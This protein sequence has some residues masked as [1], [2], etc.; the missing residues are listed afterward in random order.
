MAAALDREVMLNQVVTGIRTTRGDLPCELVIIAAG[1]RP[2]NHLAKAAGLALGRTGGIIV[3]KHMRTSDPD[4]YAGGD[5]VEI[6][7]LISGE[8]AHMP[9]GSLA[10]RQGRTLANVLAGRSDV[11]PP[12]AGAVAVKVFDRNVAATY[13]RGS[14]A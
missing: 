12:V 5:C 11:F 13:L 1:V 8:P 9:L 3:D 7:H 4:I 14:R 10:N 2:S 6:T